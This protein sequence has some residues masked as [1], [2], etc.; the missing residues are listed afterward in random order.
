MNKIIYAKKDI[1][2]RIF[3]FHEF[4]LLLSPVTA[5][6]NLLFDACHVLAGHPSSWYMKWLPDIKSLYIRISYNLLCS[7]F[8]HFYNSVIHQTLRNRWDVAQWVSIKEKFQYFELDFHGNCFHICFQMEMRDNVPWDV[9]QEQVFWIRIGVLLSA[10]QFSVRSCG[11]KYRLWFLMEGRWPWHALIG[12]IVGI[13]KKRKR[14]HA[15]NQTF[16]KNIKL[17]AV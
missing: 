12:P 11:L 9:V 16:L 10:F 4:C 5:G 1:W 8:K 15:H 2:I 3:V 13:S 6:S 14:E 17:S 7:L